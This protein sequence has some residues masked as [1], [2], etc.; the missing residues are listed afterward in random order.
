MTWHERAMVGFDLETTGVDVETD[1]IVTAS[2]VWIDVQ[3]RTVDGLRWLADTGV[4]IPAAATAVHGISTEYAVEHGKPAG[5]VAKAVFEELSSA[6]RNGIPVVV[7]NAPYDLTLLDRELRRHH[8]YGIESVG[9]VVDPLVIDRAVDRYRRGSRKLADVCRHYG[10]N[11]TDDVAHTSDGDA[12]AAARLAWCLANRY[13]AEV[14]RVDLYQ[15]R[16]LQRQSF[17]TWAAQFEA[18]LRE[19][20]AAQGS[21]P[22]EIEAVA[23]DR[24]WPLRRYTNAKEV[25]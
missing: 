23:V 13:P 25:A 20:K 5:D 18:Y 6:W 4:P 24:D 22:E 10:L 3:S 8:G 16:E 17:A 19:R 7:F 21:T 2:V 1:R 14:A 11:L 9:P 15:L 12:L